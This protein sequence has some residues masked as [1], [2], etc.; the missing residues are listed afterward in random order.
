MEIDPI[1]VSPCD[2]IGQIA[3]RPVLLM[4]GAHD[5]I[6]NPADAQALYEAAQEPK[7]LRIWPRS[8]H[9]TISS[10]E[11]AAYEN[12]LLEFFRVNLK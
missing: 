4:H 1:I 5:R 6:I 10:H 8:W 12:T 2:V 9:T 7:E 3:P 11:R